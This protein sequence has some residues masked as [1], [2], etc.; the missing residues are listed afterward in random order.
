MS[1]SN[2]DENGVDSYKMHWLQYAAFVVS[3]FVIDFDQA[4]LND[5]KLHH[6]AMKIFKFWDCNGDNPLSYYLM[7]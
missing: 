4:F 2:F 5:V 6:F 7:S 3:T 1:N